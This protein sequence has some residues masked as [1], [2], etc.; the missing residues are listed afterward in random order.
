MWSMETGNRD[1]MIKMIDLT[2]THCTIS[3]I[4]YTHKY[5]LFCIVSSEFKMLF[6]NEKGY[7]VNGGNPI[8]MSAIRL[9]NFVIFDD[10][11]SYCIVGG[12]DGVFIFNFVYKSKYEPK[13]ASQVD[14][15]GIHIKVSLENPCMVASN[16]PEGKP[17]V[18]LKGKFKDNP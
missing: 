16:D 12:I 14:P 15:K 4:A 5:R 8:D 18:V 1:M 10:R 6:M 17:K 13:L 11:K 7:V 3:A 9:V 2:K